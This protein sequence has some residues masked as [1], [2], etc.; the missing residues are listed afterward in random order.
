[1]GIMLFLLL[2]N[3]SGLELTKKQK[4]GL[5]YACLEGCP[6]HPLEMKELVDMINRLLLNDSNDKISIS[7]MIGDMEKRMKSIVY[8]VNPKYKMNPPYA[9]YT[10]HI[11]HK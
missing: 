11:Y 1:M 7:T 9:S 4:V 6:Y 2:L 3:Y 5:Y 10:L 8:W